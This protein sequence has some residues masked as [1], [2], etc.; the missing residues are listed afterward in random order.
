MT[1]PGGMTPR[2]SADERHGVAPPTL[3]D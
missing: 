2:Q 3:V 1:T